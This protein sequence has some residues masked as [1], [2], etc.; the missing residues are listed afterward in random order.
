MLF[1][2]K[3]TKSYGQCNSNYVFK[4]QWKYWKKHVKILVIIVSGWLVFFFSLLLNLSILPPLPTIF[5]WSETLNTTLEEI[6][7]DLLILLA[8]QAIISQASN[9]HGQALGWGLVGHGR[10]GSYLAFS[11]GKLRLDFRL[12]SQRLSVSSDINWGG[13][14][15]SKIKN[16]NVSVWGSCAVILFCC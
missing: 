12:S 2:R 4:I 10:E 13:F 15:I 5:W 6:M 9:S 3:D 14:L 7:P 11:S 8:S 16:N 1:S